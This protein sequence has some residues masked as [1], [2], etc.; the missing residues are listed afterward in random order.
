MVW[1]PFHRVDCKIVTL[2]RLEVLSTGRLR[3]FVDF[4]LLGTN[5]EKVLNELVEVKAHASSKSN[6]RRIILYLTLFLSRN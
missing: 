1:I 4:A 6:K 2:V 5:N 3:A